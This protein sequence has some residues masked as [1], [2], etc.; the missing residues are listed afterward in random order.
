M[1]LNKMALYNYC[2]FYFTSS[3]LQAQSREDYIGPSFGPKYAAR[4]ERQ[5]DE[6]T[7]QEGNAVIGLQMGCNRGASQSGMTPYGLSRQ[8]HDPNNY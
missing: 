8:I 6:K 7:I 1:I 4:N 5:F 3:Q 2:I